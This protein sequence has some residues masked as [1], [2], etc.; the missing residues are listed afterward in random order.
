MSECLAP[1]AIDRYLDGTSGTPEEIRAVDDHLGACARCREALETALHGEVPALGRNLARAAAQDSCPEEELLLRYV[2][3]NADAADR[4]IAEAHLALCTT[5]ARAV[6]DLRAFRA[7]MRGYNWSAARAAAGGSAPSLG[8]APLTHFLG[9]PAAVWLR[10]RV[11]APPAR[12]AAMRTGGALAVAA[13]AGLLVYWSTTRPLRREVASLRAEIGR[14]QQSGEPSRHAA[15]AGAEARAA[16]VRLAAENQRLR[17]EQG[18]TAAAVKALRARLAALKAPPRA[19]GP[20]PAA[21]VALNDG[22]RRITLDRQGNLAGLEG[23]PGDLK[24]GVRAALAR[25]RA[26][27]PAA[28][29]ALAGKAATL[30]GGPTDDVPFALRG[31]VGTFVAGDRPTFRWHSLPGATGYTV[32]VVEEASDREIASDL[33]PPGEGGGERTWALPESLPPLRRGSVYRWYVIATRAGGEAVQSPG[34]AA[35]LARFRVL[36]AGQA[37]ALERAR[38]AAG[39]S[40]LA[41]GVLYAS[42][43]LLDEAEREFRLL[44]AANPTSPVAQRLL[45]SVRTI[46]SRKGR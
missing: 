37:S 8:R 13:A 43:G 5:C 20:P 35:S 14:L 3:G 16:L 25:Q 31:P 34:R 9:A 12:R 40:H 32:Y 30:L 29:A 39:G 36:E 41:L 23:L 24:R 19:P 33:L 26:P 2:A 21:L 42:A 46:R 4:E 28:L 7:E 38:E 45:A 44:H 10:G 11:T 17:E 27:T 15:A 1:E 18:R 22:G 6:A